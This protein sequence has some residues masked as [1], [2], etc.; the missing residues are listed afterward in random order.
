[1]PAW[2]TCNRWTE[3]CLFHLC[4]WVWW[5]GQHIMLTVCNNSLMKP[6]NPNSWNKAPFPNHLLQV[7][8]SVF[9]SVLHIVG[10]AELNKQ[11]IELI[12]HHTINVQKGQNDGRMDKQNLDFLF[13]SSQTKRGICL[14]F[15]TCTICRVLPPSQVVVWDFSINSIKSN[16]FNRQKI[17]PSGEIQSL[18]GGGWQ[19]PYDVTLGS[20]AKTFPSVICDSS[21]KVRNQWK[22]QC[23][24][25]LRS[26]LHPGFR[27]Q[28]KVYRDS[29][30]NMEITLVVTVTG[31]G[32]VP[33]HILVFCI[34]LSYKINHSR[35]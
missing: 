8:S 33:R 26:T 14:G 35:R 11:S 18:S 31:W 1:M 3:I 10:K 12:R 2:I 5:V 27:T 4:T 16:I 28:M 34:Y 6:K 15:Q 30:Q 32:I 9:R 25:Y 29:L 17:N 13:A 21:N 7:L 22:I 23:M 19:V 20:D 24:A